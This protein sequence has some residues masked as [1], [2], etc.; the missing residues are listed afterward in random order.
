LPE[1]AL[2][3]DAP[4]LEE[5]SGE[6]FNLSYTFDERGLGIAV[7]KKVALMPTL[8]DELGLAR[9]DPADIHGVKVPWGQLATLIGDDAWRAAQP[10]PTPTAPLPERL[11]AQG[12]RVLCRPVANPW[13]L[14]AAVG[15]SRSREVAAAGG[16]EA[17]PAAVAPRYF[18]T[19]QLVGEVFEHRFEG[20]SDIVA[21]NQA[22]GPLALAVAPRVDGET[23]LGA[24]IDV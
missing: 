10:G 18:V 3:P 21:Q 13:S 2:G 20:R 16:A 17:A 19:A 15:D 8:E 23:V 22:G 12:V 4:I 11:W 5:R 1:N 14:S 6:V 24:T 7:T 9:G